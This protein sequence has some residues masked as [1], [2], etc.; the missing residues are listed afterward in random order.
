[1]V[2]PLGLSLGR[3]N[4]V[5]SW[6][7]LRCALSFQAVKHGKKPQAFSLGRFIVRSTVNLHRLHVLA[8]AVFAQPVWTVAVPLVAAVAV[9]RDGLTAD[10]Q[11][12]VTG[13]RVL[14]LSYPNNL[15]VRMPLEIPRRR[16][17]DEPVCAGCLPS[18]S[19]LNL[20]EHFRYPFLARP[21]ALTYIH[22]A[23]TAT[24]ASTGRP[25]SRICLRMSI[26][27]PPCQGCLV[28]IDTPHLLG[29]ESRPPARAN[30]PPAGECVCVD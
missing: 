27:V 3:A 2:Y 28:S 9:A 20:W 17:D 25:A 21:N 24:M 5:L 11:V 10:D 29:P 22:A 8:E 7:T 26:C 30:A 1:M 23:K 14:D 19:G 18:A 16:G 12:A 4:E 15:F 6:L 13:D